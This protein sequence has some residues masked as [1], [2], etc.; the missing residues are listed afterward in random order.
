VKVKAA[1][2]IPLTT[3]LTVRAEVDN[4]FDERYA[5]SS[6]NSFWIYPGAPRTVRAS[7]RAQF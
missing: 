7:L 4:L 2:E 1:A 6:Y 5:Q 3:A